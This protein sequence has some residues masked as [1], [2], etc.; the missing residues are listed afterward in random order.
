MNDNAAPFDNGDSLM[1]VAIV[2]A[3][4]TAQASGDR[5]TALRL[6]LIL[7]SIVQRDSGNATVASTRGAGGAVVER[8][9]RERSYPLSCAMP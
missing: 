4:M 2:D 3:L 8:D 6:A 5:E 1:E 7:N 9:R